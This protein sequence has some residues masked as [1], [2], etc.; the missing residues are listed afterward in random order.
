MRFE[1]DKRGL[2][3]VPLVI[4]NSLPALKTLSARKMKMCLSAVD[5]CPEIASPKQIQNPR[6]ARMSIRCQLDRR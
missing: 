5:S 3:A 2:T 6:I 4:S 1:S